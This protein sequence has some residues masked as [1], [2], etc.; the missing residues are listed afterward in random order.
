[1]S[2]LPTRP[3]SMPLFDLRPSAC[4]LLL[5]L[6]PLTAAAQP[7]AAGRALAAGN[8]RYEQGDYRGALD[9]YH[10]AL[11]AGY[12]SGALYLN[13]GN[14]Y[15]RLDELGQA[16][17]FY[18]RA[19]RYRPDDPALHH[20]LEIVRERLAD[21]F[22]PVPEPSWLRAWHRVAAW[23]PGVF[24]WP[25]LVLYALFTALLAHRIWTRTR[26]AW[27]RRALTASLLLGL[28]LLALAFS[29]SLTPAV[30]HQAVVIADETALR[31]QPLD[32]AQ[33]DLFVHEGTLLDVIGGQRTWLQVRLPNGVT[34]WVEAGATAEV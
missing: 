26:N 20:N 23:G 28:V 7:E 16:V 5:L 10:Q 32:G 18:E 22:T 33:T 4:V 9:A 12:T 15:Y 1:M 13:M 25:G 14:A 2:P 19:R 6:L 30:E 24:F 31:D 27:H 17:R 34:G 29:V 8:Q 3:E 21:R 11:E